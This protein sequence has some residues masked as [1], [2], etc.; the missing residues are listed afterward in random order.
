MKE[1]EVDGV[2]YVPLDTLKSD[3]LEH[4]R[5]RLTRATEQLEKSRL[6]RQ[7]VENDKA[8]KSHV[9]R[10]FGNDLKDVDAFIE[11]CKAKQLTADNDKEILTLFKKAVPKSAKKSVIDKFL[12]K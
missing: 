12:R 11:L 4:L 9:K 1:I 3:D 7:T 10:H 2:E 6:E 5:E 8:L